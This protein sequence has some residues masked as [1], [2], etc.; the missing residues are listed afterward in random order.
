MIT[1]TAFLLIIFRNRQR[2]NRRIVN[3]MQHVLGIGRTGRVF[4]L[5]FLFH[6]GDWNSWKSR[7]TWNSSDRS[8]RTLD[9]YSRIERFL[10]HL[11]WNMWSLKCLFQLF[12]FLKSLKR[13]AVQESLWKKAC[14]TINTYRTAV[15]PTLDLLY[16]EDF[17]AGRS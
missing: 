15:S 4:H 9:F 16:K 1:K 3:G 17:S 11:N 10:F 5:F 12:L 6:L 14:L 8:R 7:N 2:W 13:S